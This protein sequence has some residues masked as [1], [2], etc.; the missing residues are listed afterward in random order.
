MSCIA[1]INAELRISAK[2][3]WAKI[4]ADGEGARLSIRALSAKKKFID[5]QATR[6]GTKI[7]FAPPSVSMSLIADRIAPILAK[8]ILFGKEALFGLVGMSTREH[9]IIRGQI[10]TST[11]RSIAW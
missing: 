7:N 5:F 8:T 11:S 1:G 10:P 3:L 6:K 9:G 4:L 2:I